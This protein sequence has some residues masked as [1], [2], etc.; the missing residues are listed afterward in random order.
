M[1]GTFIV[2]KQVK[3]MQ[4]QDLGVSINQ[5][6][7]VK[8]PVSRTELDKQVQLFA[9]NLRQEKG[10]GSVTVAGAV[11]GME[12]AYFASNELQGNSSDQSR[13]YE[14]L[15]V[16]DRFGLFHFRFGPLGLGCLYCLKKDQGGG[17]SQ[18]SGCT[19][20]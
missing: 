19:D 11:P 16:D 14:M 20:G 17:G 12:V 2:Y 8:F 3:F 5:T 4:E 13:L 15:S 1:C 9:E 18:S 6:L 7:V 10:V